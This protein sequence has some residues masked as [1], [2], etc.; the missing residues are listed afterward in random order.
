MD[1]ELLSSIEQSIEYMKS[2]LD[3][4]ITT[5][6]LAARF[7]YSTSHFLRAFKEATGVTPRHFL[8][9]LRIDASKQLLSKPSNSS[10]KT[11][12]SVGYRSIGTFS[13]K[14]KQFVGQSPRQFKSDYHFLYE[15]TYLYKDKKV[16]SSA[17]LDS[18]SITF[19]IKAPSTFKGIVFAGLFPRPIPD[20]RPIMGTVLHNEGTS[21]FTQVPQGTYYLLAAAIHWSKNPKD[22]FNL[23]NSLRGKHEHPIQ[24][25]HDTIAEVNIDLREPTVLDPPILINLPLLLFERDKN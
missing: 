25:N 12:L 24:V 16:S 15:H 8:S 4:D 7:G 5:D 18:S 9:A 2:H 1:K 3:E 23:S 22:Y 13:T 14:F 19:H 17:P 21:V 11:L 10:L 6:Q 20:Q